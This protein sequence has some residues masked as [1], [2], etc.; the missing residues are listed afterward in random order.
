MIL[1]FHPLIEKDKNRLC[2][3]RL[4]NDE[5]L[6]AIRAADAVI[7]PQGCY[8]SLYEMARENCPHVFP[9]YDARFHFPGKSGQARLFQETGVSHPKTDIYSCVAEFR[10]RNGFSGL[11]CPVVFKFDWG[12]EGESVFLITKPEALAEILAR[13]ERFEKTGQRGF[14]LQAYIP[15][16]GRSLRMVVIG[17]KLTSYWRVAADAAAFSTGI[18]MGA[19]IAPDLNPELQLLAKAAVSDFCGKTKINLAGFDIL[20]PMNDFGGFIAT[21]LF[22]EINYFFG[23]RGL[24]G[25]DA[26]YRLFAEAVEDWISELGLR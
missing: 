7:L 17:G 2:A 5:D 10:N 22:L 19:R 23:R 13:A 4:P 18:S 3:G 8:R 9:N 21:P 11:S 14:I 20:F 1:S 25:S 6:M 16:A 12:G 24:G 15:T 26:Y